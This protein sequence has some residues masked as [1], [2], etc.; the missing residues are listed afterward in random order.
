M[1]YRVMTFR[2][3]PP[4]CVHHRR[5]SGGVLRGTTDTQAVRQAKGYHIDF[6]SSSKAGS[7]GALFKS[8]VDGQRESF[9]GLT[10]SAFDG[11]AA[12]GLRNSF[13]CGTFTSTGISALIPRS[14][15]R[16]LLPSFR[17]RSATRISFNR[18]NFYRIGSKAFSAIIRS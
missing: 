15:S 4:G 14:S 13:H 12:V 1:S 16:R 7:I 8:G 17:L 6:M 18:S 10:R 3:R 2:S 9:P 11:G 5:L